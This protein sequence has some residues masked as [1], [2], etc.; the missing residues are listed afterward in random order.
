MP[1]AQVICDPYTALGGSRGAAQF[2]KDVRPLIAEALSCVTNDG[3]NGTLDPTT[4]IEAYILQIDEGIRG[5]SEFDLVLSIE[6][7]AY[8]DREVNKD[9]RTRNLRLAIERLLP[10][11]KIGIWLKLLNASWS[12][13]NDN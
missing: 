1:L 9:D 13:A 2:I 11:K 7:Y 10:G 5:Q 3:S 8:P 4:D 12:S 6:C